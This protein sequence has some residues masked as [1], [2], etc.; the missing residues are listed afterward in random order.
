MTKRIKR[1]Q[2]LEVSLTIKNDHFI[3]PPHEAQRNSLLNKSMK[4]F[5]EDL[6][7]LNSSAKNFVPGKI[8]DG[9]ALWVK[10]TASNHDLIESWQEPIMQAMAKIV[11]ETH[12]DVL[13][14]GFG[15]GVSSTMIQK[16]YVRSH[17]IIEC[18]HS[19]IERH[20]NNWNQQFHDRDI[21]LVKGLWQDTIHDLG[22]FDGIFFHTYP[23]NAEEYMNYVNASVT[24]AAHFFA[25]AA[26]HLKPNGVF[27]YLTHEIDSFSRAHQRL[28]FQHFSSFSLQLV[29]L[30]MPEDV[31][32]TWWADSMVIVKAIK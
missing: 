2:D 25:T 16:E 17:T 6:N 8:Q 23:L 15:L 14:I 5:I 3:R 27:T 4:E 10:N 26:A 29:K 1:S 24:F 22:K 9:M 12:G 11:G 18:N 30:D 20:F 31:L 32:D 28:L 19:V 21:R 7:A 13:E